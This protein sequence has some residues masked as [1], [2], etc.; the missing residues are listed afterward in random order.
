MYF[1]GKKVFCNCDDPFE[2]N[3]FK[4]FV[5]N[6]NKLELKS[7]VV[8]SF[9]G[10]MV[11]STV[12]LPETTIHVCGNGLACPYMAEVNKVVDTEDIRTDRD[13]DYQSLFKHHENNLQKLRGDGDFRSQECAELLDGSDVVVTNPPFSLFRDFITQLMDHKKKFIII[14]NVNA[15]TYKEVFPLIRDNLIWFGASIHS[16][17]RKF[18]V[19]DDYPLNATSCGVD[20]AGR[21]YIRVK[22]VRWFTNVD[23]AQRHDKMPLTKKY[24]EAVYPRYENY[25]AIDVGRTVNIP[26]DYDGI[27][28]VPVTFLDRY[29]PDQ[30]EILMLA[31]GNARTNTDPNMLVKV[32]YKRSPLD[33]GGVGLINGKRSYARV[34]I[35]NKTPEMVGA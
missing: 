6:F 11:A 10:S 34:L 14:G 28:G 3:F 24:S 26:C 21:R 8:T 2:S 25:E 7:L 32:G 4:Y 9:A 1:E 27:M 19:P 5:L 20:K 22:G 16:G 15:V 18:Y 12:F 29:S 13:I 35:R 33:K 30:F 23:I 17:D 31:N